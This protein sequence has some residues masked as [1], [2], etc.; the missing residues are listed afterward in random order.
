M[1]RPK[2]LPTVPWVGAPVRHMGRFLDQM[3]GTPD[4]GWS[5]RGRSGSPMR[6]S[7]SASLAAVAAVA[8]LVLAACGGG[9]GGDGDGDASEGGVFED[10]GANPNT[11]NA[12][13]AAQMQPGGTL[14]FAIE[15]NIP[16]WNLNSSEGNVF[17]TGMAMKTMLPYTFTT[18]PDLKQSL[19]ES[20]LVSAEQ[21]NTSPQTIV[22]Q[23]RPEAVWNDGT[24][25]TADD[26]VFQWRTMNG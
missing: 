12:V 20:F 16:N 13:P 18:T 6:R 24:P 1:T 22:Y 9:G 15:K 10:C 4:P 26:F 19:N 7:R 23:I 21:T 2:A 5:S 17:E 14:T 25:I 8:T 11:C 3:T